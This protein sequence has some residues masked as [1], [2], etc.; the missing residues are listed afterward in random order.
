MARLQH[1]NYEHTLHE[2]NLLQLP[3]VEEER[4]EI[5]EGNAEQRV[6]LS[7]RSLQYLNMREMRIHAYRMNVEATTCM[8]AGYTWMRQGSCSADHSILISMN[9]P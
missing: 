7:D 8:L 2:M 6:L 5:V 1:P 4:G 9:M 3:R